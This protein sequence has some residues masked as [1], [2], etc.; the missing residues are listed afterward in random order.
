MTGWTTWL[1]LTIPAL[2]RSTSSNTS[3]INAYNITARYPLAARTEIPPL[4]HAHTQALLRRYVVMA[5][6]ASSIVLRNS[7]CHY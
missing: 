2:L 7:G 3:V 1:S 5:K 4:V 6:T